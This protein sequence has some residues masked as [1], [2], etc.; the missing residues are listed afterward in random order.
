[1]YCT[2]CGIQL[3]QS[4][5]FC[6]NC[7]SATQNAPQRPI[8]GRRLT[9]SRDDVKIAGVCSGIARYFGID[10][11]IVRILFV[12]FACWPPLAGAIAYAICWIVIPK[13]PA[14]LLPAATMEN[15]KSA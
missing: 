6:S 11:T 1:M 8:S 14:G 10:P 12:V 3:D 15:A 7:G 5:S 4:A 13:E 9:R 2:H